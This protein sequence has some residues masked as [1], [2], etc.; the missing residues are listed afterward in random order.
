MRQPVR[1]GVCSNCGHLFASSASISRPTTIV[2]KQRIFFQYDSRRN[3]SWTSLFSNL[4]LRGKRTE[5]PPKPKPPDDEA[6]QR[7]QEVVR[8]LRERNKSETTARET[9]KQT[10]PETSRQTLKDLLSKDT[11]IK[12]GPIASIPFLPKPIP[13]KAAKKS[14]S[15]AEVRYTSN[16]F[17]SPLQAEQREAMR[18][19]LAMAH[20][21]KEDTAK[22]ERYPWEEPPVPWNTS[23]D[24][25]A[26]IRRLLR[27][28]AQ[29]TPPPAKPPPMPSASDEVA[30]IRSVRDTPRADS[31]IY[32]SE[33]ADKA[34][35]SSQLYQHLRDHHL[36]CQVSY[37]GPGAEEAKAADRELQRRLDIAFRQLDKFQAPE[38][39]LWYR[40][41]RS[42]ILEAFD[43]V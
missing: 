25:L 9:G 14:I 40:K 22:R 36:R 17:L 8:R 41:F 28:R 31:D 12:G 5:T 18:K 3:V 32:R 23:T 42:N 2:R 27:L 29:T 4:N 16:P 11:T 34:Q 1:I 43:P 38:H 10:T 37:M 30:G 7:A 35:T 20:S 26:S 39:E 21:A 24:K 19:Y 13:S 15:K 6:R 33:K